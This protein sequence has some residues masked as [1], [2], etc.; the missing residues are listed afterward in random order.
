MNKTIA[1]VFQKEDLEHSVLLGY[2][3][4]GN[5]GD[6][7]L[8]EVLMNLFTK[9]DVHS[10]TVAYLH[11][12]RYSTYHHN[13]GFGLIDMTDKWSVLK[14][15]A[16]NKNVIIGGGGLW[17][18]DVNANIFLF[19]SL[20]FISRFFLRKKV[21]LLGV[22]YYDSTNKLGHASAWLAG[23]AAN[24]IIVRDQE[25]LQNFQKVSTHVSQD[26]DI[27]YHVPSLN[28]KPYRPDFVALDQAIRIDSKTLFITLRR[29]KPHQNNDFAKN[30]EACLAHNQDIN[31]I[32]ATLEPREIDSTGYKLINKWQKQYQN[33]QALD[34]SYNPVALF[35]FF[36]KNKEQLALIGPQFHAIIIALLTG[37]TFLPVVY[38]NKVLE[39]LKK[40][41]KTRPIQINDLSQHE[42][43]LF[44]DKFKQ[45]VK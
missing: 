21:Y 18:L 27:A 43:Q 25:S 16:K 6:E 1:D 36:Q 45:A 33:V 15:I 37:V 5:F 26:A 22:G 35:L 34:F 40:T 3:G 31:I 12:E 4:G 32:V 30:I 44:I 41:T 13:F 29:F 17:G 23:K 38:D 10:L 42:L 19:S 9:H 7:L 8:L 2:Y 39:L 11:A 24:Y 14:A 28:L 20:L